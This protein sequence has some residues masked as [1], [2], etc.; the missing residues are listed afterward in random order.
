MGDASQRKAQPNTAHLPQKLTYLG[1]GVHH[2]EHQGRY[3]WIPFQL[4]WT[5]SPES[6]FSSRTGAP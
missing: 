2:E 5:K 4:K 6:L 3:H 1:S